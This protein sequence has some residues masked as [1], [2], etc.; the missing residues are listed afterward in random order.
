MQIIIIIK[1]A[2]FDYGY[3]IYV[4]VEVVFELWETLL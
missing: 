4:Y 3:L 2:L 1:N